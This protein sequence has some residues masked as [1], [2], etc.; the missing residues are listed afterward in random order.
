MIDNIEGQIAAARQ[1]LSQGKIETAARIAADVLKLSPASL[2]ALEVKALCEAE[3]GNDAAAEATLRQAIALAPSRRWHYGDLARLLLRLGRTGEAEQIARTAIA[4]DA[5][6]ADAHAI[7]A[8][9]L[10]DRGAPFEAA[11][12]F[13]QAIT[14]VGPH[15]QLLTGLGLSL[16]RQGRLEEARPVLERAAAADATALEPVAYL[17]ELEERLGRFSEAEQLLDRAQQL[18]TARGTDVD[19]Q[20]SVLLA[21]KGQ[22]EDALAL[23]EAK[24]EISGAALLQRGRL[25]DRMGRYAEG[26]GDWI[27]GKAVLAARGERAYPAADVRRQAQD[28]AAFFTPDRVASFPRAARRDGLAQ[29]I[30]IIGFPRS[31]TTL[32]EQILASHSAISA[33]GELPFGRELRDLAAKLVGGEANFPRSLEQHPNWPERLR[34]RYLERAKQYGLTDYGGWFTDKMPLN[35][36]WLPLLRIAFPDSPVVLV[37]RHPLDVL[38]SVMAHDMTH[39]FDC[40][41]R[42]ED[43]AAHLALIDDLI[44]CYRQAGIGPTHEL[45]YERLIADQVGETPRLMTS[46]GLEME[47]SQLRFF[48]RET[49]SP[50]PSYAQVREPLNDGSIGRW[51]NYAEQLEPIMPVVAKA[52]ERGGY[53]A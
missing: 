4:S 50:T 37:R 21:R 42:L 49:V 2:D 20:R 52:M 39:G 8:S 6:N 53:A 45:Q 15:P 36:M 9:L 51:R 40:A 26:W 28:L 3:Q 23:L 18:A 11:D 17:A 38:V 5:N 1:A 19:L 46:I 33:G 7:L 29:P 30:F 32:T 16:L 22:T 12:H 43:A 25:R 41:Y 47:P 44:S 35:D 27:S 10:N 31:G 24:T 13:R 34:D 48:E 14:L